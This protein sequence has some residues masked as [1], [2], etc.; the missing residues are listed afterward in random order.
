MQSTDKFIVTPRGGNNFVN[1][2]E[3]GGQTMIVNTSIE[4][5]INVNRFGVIVALPLNY[6]GNIQIG[7]E[8]VVQHNVFRDWFDSKGVTRKSVCYFKENLY[9]LDEESIFLIFRDGKYISVDYYCFIEPIVEEQ[10]WIGK[11]E[12]E[13]QG[14]VKFPNNYLESQGVFAGDRIAFKTD[15][16]YEFEIDGQKLYRMRVPNV[17]VKIS[18]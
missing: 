3:I 17:L 15:S 7:D 10:R 6:S 11:V 14:I 9:F 16:E 4:E 5:A 2:K 8:V 1:E 12:V 18:A 13:H